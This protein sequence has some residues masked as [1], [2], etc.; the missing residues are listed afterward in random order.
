MIL[1]NH[2]VLVVGTDNSR[3]P[4]TRSTARA[5]LPV[6]AAGDGGDERAD[7]AAARS[8]VAATARQYSPA[9]ADA[10]APDGDGRA[11]LRKLDRIDPGYRS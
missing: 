3:R 10:S 11:L 7:R 2:G 1:R 8:S 6:A 5:R 9:C 4:S